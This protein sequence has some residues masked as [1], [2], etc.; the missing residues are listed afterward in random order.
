MMGGLCLLFIFVSISPASYLFSYAPGIQGLFVNILKFVPPAGILLLFSILI[1]VE[2]RKGLQQIL[3]TPLVS[4]IIVFE[5]VTFLSSLGAV[6]PRLG[7]SRDFYYAIT[8]PLIALVVFGGIRKWGDFRRFVELVFWTATAVSAYGILEFVLDRNPIF[9]EVFSAQNPLYAQFALEGTFGARIRSSVGHPV[10][11]GAYLLML[12]PLGWVLASEPRRSR[13][14]RTM[15]LSGVLCTIAALLL[16]FSRGAWGG[17]GVGMAVYSVLR[18]RTERKRPGVVATES[19]RIRQMA[20]IMAV[21]LVFVALVLNFDKISTTLM[22]RGT[23]KQV[24]AFKTDP[25]GVA[26]AQ[27]AGMVEDHPLLGIGTAH[28]RYLARHYGDY[29][30]TPD[31]GY[32]RTLAENGILG[33]GSMIAVFAGLL[34]VLVRQARHK[35]DEEGGEAEFSSSLSVALAASFAGFFVDMVTSDALQFP[36]TRLT[37]WM[38]AGLTI[39][40]D[41]KNQER[42]NKD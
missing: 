23:L 40:I 21:V 5:T 2:R 25:R 4:A 7:L 14:Y 9:E 33:L 26:Y 28:Y 10:F 22:E 27:A 13:T 15:A 29:D 35:D 24:R 34:K 19:G 17:I 36:L 20:W 39:A 16:T 1:W 11:L 31:N 6:E 30:D 38:L 42:L 32:L 41:R 37:F 18:V 3:R 8:G 12:I